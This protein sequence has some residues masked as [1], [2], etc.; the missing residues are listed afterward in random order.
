MPPTARPKPVLVGVDASA[1]AAAAAAFACRLARALGTTCRLV[2]AVPNPGVAVAGVP[3]PAD[4][5]EYRAALAHEARNEVLLALRDVELPPEA[6][7]LIVHV[8]RPARVLAR[9]AA[10]LDAGL[11]VLGGKHHGTLDRWFGGLTARS[12]VRLLHIPVLVTRD[13]PTELRRILVATD[14]SSAVHPTLDL[15]Q[16]LAT[17][18]R[19]ALSMVHVHEPVPERLV[20]RFPHTAEYY[21]LRDARLERDVWPHARRLKARKVVRT[22][23]VPETLAH[24]AQVDHADLLVVGSHGKGLVDRLLIGSVTEELLER[25]PTSLLIV[26]IPPAAVAGAAPQAAREPAAAVG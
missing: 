2:H 3:L 22:G 11:V 1:E 21:A 9:V 12:A 19:A 25:L 18:F 15:A 26:P 4:F 23:L 14:P 16:R 6:R 7:D 13:P 10:E 17:A 20:S 8:G 5:A 24:E